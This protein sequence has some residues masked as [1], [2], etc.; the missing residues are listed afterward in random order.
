MNATRF[1]IEGEWSGYT[2]AQQRVVHRQVYPAGRK[3]LRAWAER[4]HAIHYSDGTSLI[5]SVR[6][7]KP[8][9]RVKEVR[10]YSSLIEDCAYHDV[11]SVN[12]LPR[13]SAA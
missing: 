9:E 1:V 10:G 11:S 6:D 2:S 13:R 5:L 7:C 12:D 4:T 8:R 3:R